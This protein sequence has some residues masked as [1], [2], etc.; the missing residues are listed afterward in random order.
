MRKRWPRNA[1]LF[2]MIQTQPFFELSMPIGENLSFSKTEFPDGDRLKPKTTVSIVS[3]MHGDELDG[4]YISYLLHQYFLSRKDDIQKLGGKIRLIPVMNPAGVDVSHRFWPFTKIDI[5][6]QFPGDATGESSQRISQAIFDQLKDSDI[7]IDIHS[8]NLFVFEV[9]QVRI[10]EKFKEQS[11]PLT[12]FLGMDLVW[13]HAAPTVI[14]T[15]LS[16]NLN[17]RSIPT[18]VIECGISHRLTLAYCE[19][20]FAGILNL[21]RHLKILNDGSAPVRKTARIANESNVVYLNAEHAGI[22]VSKL[23]VGAALKQNSVIGEIVDPVLGKRVEEIR[24]PA[25]GTLFT[26]RAHP[27]CYVGS[28]LGRIVREE[29]G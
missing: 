14:E 4:L 21:L 25:D 3:G 22:F 29:R 27:I 23:N 2:K 6:R 18:L 28:L 11:L 10:L 7:V 9:P 1:L 17:Q 12:E 8:S 24:A 20:I 19:Q 26:L 15:T 5:N 16:Y 13:I